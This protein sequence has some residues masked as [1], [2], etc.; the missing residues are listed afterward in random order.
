MGSQHKVCINTLCYLHRV[1]GKCGSQMKVYD[2]T[3]RVLRPHVNQANI[4]PKSRYGVALAK[5]ETFEGFV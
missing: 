1:G 5:G 4:K 3:K 2:C